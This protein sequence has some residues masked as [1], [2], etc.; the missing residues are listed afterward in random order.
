M[1]SCRQV[2]VCDDDAASG[3]DSKENSKIMDALLDVLPCRLAGGFT[4]N[5]RVYDWLDKGA[6]QV[7]VEYAASNLGFLDGVPKV[8]QHVFCFPLLHMSESRGTFAR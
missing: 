8:S 2:V 3:A 1:R 6:S 5:D 4:T 7:I